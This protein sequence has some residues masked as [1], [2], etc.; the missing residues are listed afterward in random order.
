MSRVTCVADRFVMTDRTHA[1]DLATGDAVTMII[2]QAGAH[3]EHARWVSRCDAQYAY[4]AFDADN[5]ID[6]GRCGES[7]RFEAWH[8]RRSSHRAVG[9]IVGLRHVERPIER[10]LAELFE[11]PGLRSRA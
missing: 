7:Q 1:I 3:D 9:A 2:S 5:L 6:F 4:Y 8:T 11:R 10:A